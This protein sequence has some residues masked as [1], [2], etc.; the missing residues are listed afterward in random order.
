MQQVINSEP[1]VHD[2]LLVTI[3]RRLRW[4]TVGIFLV[5]L[6]LLFNVAAVFG[7]IIEFHSREGILIGSACTGGTAMGFLFGW[8]AHRAMAR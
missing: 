4:Q 1:A 2:P 7:A 3:D 6:E 8:L 5:A